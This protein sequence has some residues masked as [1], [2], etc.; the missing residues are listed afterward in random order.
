[1]ADLNFTIGLSAD[2]LIQGAAQAQRALDGMDKRA[3]ALGRQMMQQ[4][5]LMEQGG[6]ALRLYKIASANVSESDKKRL[7]QME[8]ATQ[9]AAKERAAQQERAAGVAQLQAAWA[10]E[11]AAQNAKKQAID[12]SIAAM[13]KEAAVLG[14]TAAAQKLYELQVQGATQAQLKQVAALQ[15]QI[16]ARQRL[17]QGLSIGIGGNLGG[18]ALAAVGIGG[19]A[20]ILKAADEWTVFQNRLKL[21]TSTAAELKEAQEGILAVAKRT[22]QDLGG[23]AEV[24]QR[25]AANQKELGLNG[26]ELLQITETINKSIVVGGSTAEGASAA[27]TQF[28]QAMASGVLRG[29][30]FN[31]MMEQA[32]GLAR[33]L[34]D[35]LGVGVGQ[36]RNMANNGE[37]TAERVTQALLKA[38]VNVDAQFKKM[39][40]TI[41]QSATNFKTSLTEFI[42][43]SN[44]ASGAAKVLSGAIQFAAEHVD[45]LA[46]GITLLVA[47]SVG[48]WAVM[49]TA[50]VLTYA[51][52]LAVAHRQGAATAVSQTATAAA[53]GRTG[54]A[55]QLAALNVGTFGGSL[56]A[57]QLA[58]S[59]ASGALSGF[60]SA[61]AALLKVGAA[62]IAA[63]TA[64]TSLYDILNGGDGKNWASDGFD[65]LLDKLG[66]IDSRV[67]TLGTKLAEISE[68]PLTDMERKVTNFSPIFGHL[69]VYAN[70]WRESLT[71]GAKQL[72]RAAAVAKTIQLQTGYT[73]A[74]GKVN[75][76][77]G[78]AAFDAAAQP[79][80][81]LRAEIDNSVIKYREQ[82]EQI[83]KT[84]IELE[85]MRLEAQKQAAL[86]KE[87]AEAQKLYKDLPNAAQLVAEQLKNSAAQYDKS[88]ASVVENM[89]LTEQATRE[90]TAA[91]KAQTA[92][93]ER[94]RAVTESLQGLRD[95]LA[96]VGKT[97]Q[98]IKLMDLADKG[99]TAAQLAE[100]KALLE[101]TAAKEKAYEAAQAKLSDAGGTMLKAAETMKGVAE[102]WN[103]EPDLLKGGSYIQQQWAA[104]KAKIDAAN[105]AWEAQYG[106]ARSLASMV[107]ESRQN[108]NGDNFAKLEA[109]N[110]TAL[111]AAKTQAQAADVF[112]AAA[113]KMAEA[114]AKPTGGKAEDPS[115]TKAVREAIQVSALRVQSAYD[116]ARV[117]MINAQVRGNQ[118]LEKA[119]AASVQALKQQLDLH[120]SAFADTYKTV[121]RV[122]ET[123]ARVAAAQVRAADVFEAAAGKVA[124]AT[125]KAG[126][127]N[128]AAQSLPQ[129]QQ[130]QD[131]GRVT[132]DMRFPDGKTL[133]GVLFGEQ[134][135][136]KQ[137][138]AATYKNIDGYFKDMHTALT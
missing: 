136:I 56:K 113:G 71:D 16:A 21:V 11:E 34:A 45:V 63:T 84:K 138:K 30:E 35:G 89:T 103:G 79:L 67:E 27:L 85:K 135:F 99:A 23:T 78:T 128:T 41:A 1:M 109:A 68:K 94:A 25:L 43:K 14:K 24:Y 108:G 44:E 80:E 112:G 22:G 59:A 51:A 73:S 18:A 47:L 29:E 40:L 106:K 130:P 33:A 9:A 52:A 93:L 105:A 31:S 123:A 110:E 54:A 87:E 98:E 7:L 90:R 64:L 118:D 20:G 48:K 70:R 137:F 5:I 120:E 28:E 26:K 3:Q 125:A 60:I 12:K 2:G 82:A 111:Q 46:A 91:E 121:Q 133:T 10:R 132:L 134:A 15:A 124:D 61:N 49:T 127:T 75:A 39:D 107:A 92:A 129:V 37:L 38:G 100:A 101:A 19:T 81:K 74:I 88:I 42:G 131:M 114:V 50:N 58:G 57:L 76:A 95:N 62:A 77:G 8:L 83:G 97:A 53:I 13:Q 6:D 119:Y 32:P 116:Q 36:L 17:S 69:V 102:Q 66:L 55:A 96:R 86:K 72:E 104:E 4:Q 115:Y 126:G 117:G 122:D 65:Q